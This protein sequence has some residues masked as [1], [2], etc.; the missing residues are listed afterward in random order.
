MDFCVDVIYPFILVPIGYATKKTGNKSKNTQKTTKTQKILC[1]KDKNQQSE[2]KIYT[3]DGDT[4]K[5]Y[6]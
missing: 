2:E 6:I 3:I 1:I 5:S 4:C